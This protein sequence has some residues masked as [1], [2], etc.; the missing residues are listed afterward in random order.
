[1]RIAKRR[2]DVPELTGSPADPPTTLARG[3][4]SSAVPRAER[5]HPGP[6]TSRPAFY[7]L[8]S[9]GWRDYI[10][11]LHLPYTLWHLSY[12]IL[13]AALS[14]TLREGRLVATLLAFFLAVGVSAH[15]LD[16]LNGRPLQTRIRRSILIAL[17]IGGL[18]GAVAIGLVGAIL[19]SPWLLAFVAFGAFIAPA[20]NLEWSR[21]RFHSDFWFAVA[22][23]VFP[24]LTAYYAS[25]E[26]FELSALFG[27]IAV[28]ALSL[29]Q[30]TLS[31]RVRAVRREVRSIEG[32][33]VFAD[34][35]LEDIDRHWAL[36]ADEHA[37][38]LLSITIIAL[39]VGA[40]LTRV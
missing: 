24:F 18:A 6:K 22:W 14:P 31:R 37:L 33:I 35:N 1:V 23:G 5:L 7:A 4:A 17:G 26:R 36:S 16:E 3:T 34:G 21:G 19:A 32:R 38:Q 20:Y 27:A 8:R 2:R 10:T 13:G 25:A 30:R 39:S 15:A 9:G 12:V 28:F 11:L 40:L 29:A